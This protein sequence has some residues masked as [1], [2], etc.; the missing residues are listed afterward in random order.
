MHSGSRSLAAM[1]VATLA[2]TPLAAQGQ[3]KPIDPANLDTTCAPCQNFFQYA[4]GGWLKRSSIPA[5]QPRWGSF[6]EL[7]EQNY[8]TLQGV[9]TD[10]AKNASSTKDPNI[11]KLGSFTA[12]VWTR[13]PSRRRGS[14]RFSRSWRRSTPFTIDGECRPPSPGY[15]GWVS[16]RASSSDRSLTPRRARAPSPRCTK[17]AWGFPIE[18]TT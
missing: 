4:N 16:R 5:D 7:Q 1:L 13:L 3:A 6:N 12:P 15:M 14:G 17:A 2:A 11:R 18:T 8:A 9:L 10:A